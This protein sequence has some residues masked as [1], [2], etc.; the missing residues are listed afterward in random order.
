MKG[1]EMKDKSKL[2]QDDND[3]QL[4]QCFCIGPEN[5]EDEDCVL[6][7]N[8]KDAHTQK[9]SPHEPSK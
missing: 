5:C 8:Y 1:D 3:K 6:V 4:K 7:K 2:Y 9:R